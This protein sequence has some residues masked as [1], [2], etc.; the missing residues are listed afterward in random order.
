MKRFLLATAAIA[1]LAV[2]PASAQTM[3]TSPSGTA[4]TSK[5][6]PCM[7]NGAPPSTNIDR[8]GTG[9]GNKPST[10]SSSGVT[11]GTRSLNNFRIGT[12]P[13]TASDGTAC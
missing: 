2:A 3:G 13:N 9:S 12:A 4:P 6:S 5:S 8:S 7:S 11:T 10:T 1:I